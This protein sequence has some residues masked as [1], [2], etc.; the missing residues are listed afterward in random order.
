MARMALP[1]MTMFT[2]GL[3]LLSAVAPAAELASPELSIPFC[4]TAPA[5]D[6]TIEPDEWQFAAAVSMLEACPSAKVGSFGRR[7][8]ST[9]RKRR[10]ARNRFKPWEDDVRFVG[11][12][13]AR[14][15]VDCDSEHVLVSAYHAPRGALFVVGNTGEKDTNAAISPN[16][17]ALGLIATDV[18]ASDAETDKALPV[19]EPG[20]RL[21]V[22]V[23]RHDVR[24][25]LVRRRGG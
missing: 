1:A 16:W 4:R 15:I 24:L 19:I 23:P 5:I 8:R 7:D 3:G 21:C 13:E 9:V 2:A 18:A 6:G 22:G 12:W 14:G 17:R 20:G 11:Y 25:V 10:R